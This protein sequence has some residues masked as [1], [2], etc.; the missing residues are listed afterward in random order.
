MPEPLHDL[1]HIDEHAVDVA[2]P[3][4]VT[5]AA[6]LAALHDTFTGPA[7]RSVA[8]VLGCAPATTTGPDLPRPGAA[9]PGFRVI[10]AEE[11]RLL[12]LA[13]RHRFSRYGI[14]VRLD[15]AGSGTRVRLESRAAFPGP[16][17]TLYRLAVVGTG[18]HVVAVRRL[19]AGVRRAAGA[20]SS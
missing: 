13:G 5:W 14:V 17:G 19:L 6:V 3:T 4:E 11:P 12:V 2:T 18:G 20:T 1:P 9:V 10:T 16:H 7:A 15:P 8:R